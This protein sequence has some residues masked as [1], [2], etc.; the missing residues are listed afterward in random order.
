[1]AVEAVGCVILE[2]SGFL[3]LFPRQ[4]DPRDHGPLATPDCWPRVGL[5]ATEPEAQVGSSWL[6]LP[7]GIPTL[8]DA[9]PRSE[10]FKLP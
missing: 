4:G 1:M 3:A 7:T 6:H 5:Y 10:Q 8:P 2:G 9:I